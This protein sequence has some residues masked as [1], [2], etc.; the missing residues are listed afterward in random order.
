M[1]RTKLSLDFNQTRKVPRA[2]FRDYNPTILSAPKN[3][4]TNLVSNTSPIVSTILPSPE[5]KG[6]LFNLAANDKI[7][8]PITPIPTPV[9]LS[10]S[11]LTQSD[12]EAYVKGFLDAI[13][14][15][16]KQNATKLWSP[17]QQNIPSFVALTP[18]SPYK[19]QFEA[20]EL[21]PFAT[22]PSTNDSLNSAPIN[23]STSDKNCK[24]TSNNPVLQQPSSI[25]SPLG[26][27]QEETKSFSNISTASFYSPLSSPT[28]SISTHPPVKYESDSDTS[29]NAQKSG[30]QPHLIKSQ[31]QLFSIM[32]PRECSQSPAIKRNYEKVSSSE[33][34]FYSKEHKELARLV[35][36]REKNRNAARKC[37][38]K[39]LERIAS[40]EER[41]RHL[42]S[43]NQALMTT[44]DKSK[45][46]VFNLQKNLSNHINQK[47]CKL[48]PDGRTLA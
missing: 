10:N 46:E 17:N 18:L 5:P 23:L 29:S 30:K 48:F 37:R 38:T 32:S 19:P 33:Q 7:L 3:D 24:Q 34:T 47:K 8:L 44:L 15:L 13:I 6:N 1:D 31:Q 12:H 36:R 45:L 40:L 39:K 16:Q 35:Q 27:P 4:I 21:I 20:T 41:V 11:N 43:E 25:L 9:Y 22:V 2:T 14:E 28:S 42:K 26:T